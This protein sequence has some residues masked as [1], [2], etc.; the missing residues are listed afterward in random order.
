MLISLSTKNKTRFVD[1]AIKKRNLTDEIYKVWDRCSITMISWILSIL[2]QDIARSVLYFNTTRDI[3]INLEE[4]YRHS[5]GTMLFSLKQS[6]FDM[7]QGQDKIVFL[8]T[9]P[10]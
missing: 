4:R 10:K 3:W 9:I 6:L 2:D 8:P 1:G 7:K 5:S